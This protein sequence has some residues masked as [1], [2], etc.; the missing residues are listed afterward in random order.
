MC[1]SSGVSCMAINKDSVAFTIFLGALGAL[2]PLSI[3]MNLPALAS[4][5]VSLHST[6]S[7]TTLTLSFFLLGFALAPVICGP[8]SDRFGRRPVLM[9]GAVIFALAAVACA[10][11]PSID[12]L[13]A[14]RLLQGT[15][16]GACSVLAMAVVRDLFEGN[17]ARAR[18][19]YVSIVRSIAPMIAPTIGVFIL[20]F[21]N[22]RMIFALLALAGLLLLAAIA[23]G[24]KESAPHERQPL[25]PSALFSNY[26]RVLTDPVSCGYACINALMFGNIFAY[27]SNSPLLLIKALHVPAPIFGYIFGFTAFGIMVG[28]FV[29][30]RLSTQGIAHRIPLMIGLSLACTSSLINVLLNI[31]GY[32]SVYTLV[33]FIFV[34]VF[35]IG[36][37]GPNAAHGCLQPMPKIAGIASAVMAFI[38]MVMGAASSA[39]VA[40]LYDGRSAAAMTDVMLGFALAAGAVYLFVVRPAER[41]APTAST[42]AIAPDSPH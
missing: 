38:Q 32:A 39:L 15:G 14:S 18:L 5:A 11:A 31:S 30:G 29:N 40:F 10:L 41:R 21:S 27:V 9:V 34:C 23:F 13:L 7:A 25:T 24:F 42:A 19:S 33:P 26:K 12:L 35:S 17:E 16:A 22:W 37:A 3:D 4:T 6:E 8:L 20:R 2:P 1:D 36:L 28:A